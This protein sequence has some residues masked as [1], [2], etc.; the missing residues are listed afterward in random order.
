VYKVYKLFDN[1]NIEVSLGHKSI[2]FNHIA[3]VIS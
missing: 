1:M 2:L 3:R